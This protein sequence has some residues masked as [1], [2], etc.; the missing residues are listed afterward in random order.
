MDVVLRLF[1]LA[2]VFVSFGEGVEGLEV[3][4]GHKLGLSS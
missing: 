3:F 2:G 4:D 1:S